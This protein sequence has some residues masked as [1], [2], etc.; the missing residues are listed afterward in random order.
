M[1]RRTCLRCD[2]EGDAPTDACPRCGQRPLY[3]VPPADARPNVRPPRSAPVATHAPPI[4]PV[5]TWEDAAPSEPPA[6]PSPTRSSI[7]FVVLAA[8]AAILFVATWH[9]SANQM[10]VA[11]ASAPRFIPPRPA[12][13]DSVPVRG[14]AA[15]RHALVV[16]GVRFSFEVPTRGWES[17]GPIS[18]S[19]SARGSH[20]GSAIVLWTALS[21][22]GTA[23]PCG[24][25]L[26]PPDRPTTADAA[27]AM[28]AAPGV[29][30]VA[31]AARTTVGGR[32]AMRVSLKVRRDVGCDP[33][34][35][36]SWQDSGGRSLWPGTTRGD[37][38]RVWVVDVPHG[39]FVIETETTDGS[40]P[41]LHREIG[42]IVGSM[43]FG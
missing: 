39:P 26:R 18:V 29:E 1:F 4:P 43:R 23:T 15:R 33:G 22:G 30:I 21:R 28:Q 6:Q 17:F 27:H 2:W 10:P 11:H 5:A 38:I 7:G 36:F 14:Y 31:P 16:D 3:V 13:P 8:L 20:D 34:Y 32:P 41:E 25:V 24:A 12:R 37:R 9:R 42:Q 19:M 40:G 35:F